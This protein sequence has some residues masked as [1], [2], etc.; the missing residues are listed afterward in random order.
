MIPKA[1]NPHD[2]F[3]LFYQNHL[4]IISFRVDACVTGWDEMCVIILK[5]I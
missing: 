1:Y 3:A 2:I 5:F 4:T